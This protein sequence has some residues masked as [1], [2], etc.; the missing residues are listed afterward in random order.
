[1][2][3]MSLIISIIAL[4][5]SLITLWL[6]K[7]RQGT[8]K[9]TRPTLICFKPRNPGGDTSKIFFRTLLYSTSEKGQYVENMYVKVQCNEVIQDFSIWA[10]AL[11]EQIVRGSGLFVGKEGIVLN[12][13]FLLPKSASNFEFKEGAYIL[14]I[15]V[16]LTNSKP[17]KIYTEKLSINDSQEKA[18]TNKDSVLYFN[19]AS[20]IQAYQSHIDSMLERIHDLLNE[21]K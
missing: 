13:H 4:I 16:E 21:I 10:Y 7:L 5:V 8:I 11:D 17:K 2:D 19:W 12:H 1:M 15:F 3:L 18:L 20:D 14:D 9:M 6:T